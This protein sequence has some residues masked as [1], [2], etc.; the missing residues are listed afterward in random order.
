MLHCTAE[1][2]DDPEQFISACAG[3]CYSDYINLHWQVDCEAPSS[4]DA[5]LTRVS[6]RYG[7]SFAAF[8]SYI[9]TARSQFPNTNIVVTEFALTAPASQAQQNAFFQQALPF[10]DGLRYVV[11]YSPFVVCVSLPPLCACP[12]ADLRSARAARRRLCFSRTIPAPS[13]SSA[14]ARASTASV[15]SLSRISPTAR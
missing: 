9:Q 4:S 7:P 15:S 8:Q 5:R 12:H 11:Y 13:A 6:R 2:T 1:I 3:R 10:L 14:P